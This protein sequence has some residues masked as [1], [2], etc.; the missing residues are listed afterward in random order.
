MFF[1]VNS[2]PQTYEFIN[3]DEG[4]AIFPCDQRNQTDI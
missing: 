1:C 3:I 4:L 2:V